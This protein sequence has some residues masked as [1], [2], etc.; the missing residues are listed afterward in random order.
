[1]SFASIP[2]PIVTF[3]RAA[4]EHDLRSLLGSFTSDA[5]L[6]DEGR[7]Y[8]GEAITHWTHRVFFREGVTVHPI[9]LARRDHKLILT[10]VVS[11]KFDEVSATRPFQADWWFTI[12]GDRLSA[13]T[14]VR[15]NA[16]DLPAPLATYVQATNTFDLEALFLGTR[17]SMRRT[18]AQC[19]LRRQTTGPSNPSS[20]PSL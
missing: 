10:V 18:R 9:N 14:I 17:L 2:P 20:I 12:S 11:G 1:M 13:V 8:R 5:V 16:P 19:G 6:T 7:E 15:E 3:L 4:R